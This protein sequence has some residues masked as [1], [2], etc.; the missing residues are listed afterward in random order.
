MQTREWRKQIDEDF[1]KFAQKIGLNATQEMEIREIAENAFKQLMALLEEAINQPQSEVDWAA[2]D[3]KTKE[4][5]KDAEA[6]I[7][8]L[9]SEEQG[10]A[11]RKFF[12]APE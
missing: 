5:Y 6:Q 11:L 8:P 3:E 4:I 1:P 7:V 2:L 12:K 9:V 10:K